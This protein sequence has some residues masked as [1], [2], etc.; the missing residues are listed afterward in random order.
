M[1]IVKSATFEKWIEKLRDERARGLIIARLFRLEE[2]QF[3]DVSPV[4]EGISELRVHYG[5]GYRIYFYR[6]GDEIVVLLCGGDKSSQP[7]DI[8]LAHTILAEWKRNHG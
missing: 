4:G 1:N 7:R 3:G 2:G 6:R 8:K 5:P